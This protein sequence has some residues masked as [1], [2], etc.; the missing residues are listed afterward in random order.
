MFRKGVKMAYTGIIVN[1]KI[2]YTKEVIIRIP[3]ITDK[4]QA[5]RLIGKKVMWKNRKK[6]KHYGKVTGL[7]GS[8]GAIKAKFRI[9]LPAESLAKLV[10][11][12]D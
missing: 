11:I 3:E 12:Y 4:R 8:S 10:E 6:V 2:P 1:Y 7:H 5:A 9:P